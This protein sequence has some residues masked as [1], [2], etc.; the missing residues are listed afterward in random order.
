M[1]EAQVRGWPRIVSL[2][3]SIALTL[4]VGAIGRLATAQSVD[5][6]YAGLNKPSFNPPN[7]V[8]GPA[9]TTLYILMAVAAWRIYL[10]PESRSRRAA[11]GLY[12]VQLV[13]NL[14]WSIVFF[15][16]RSPFPALLNLAVLLVAVATMGM[17]FWRLD[18]SAGL[19][20]VPYMLWSTFAF[21]LNLEIWRLN[22]VG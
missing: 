19:L 21:V 22:R 14:G 2:C 15:G 8:F 10:G 9:W 16:L 6:W 13:L 3:L 11:L 12:G 5:T 17:S 18:R 4:A 7:W 1:S 20:L